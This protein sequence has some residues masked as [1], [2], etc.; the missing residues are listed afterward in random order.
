[1]FGW[2]KRHKILTGL[3]LVPFVLG[4]LNYSGMCI[5]EGR[6]L[7][8]EE[9]IRKVVEALLS[10]ERVPIEIANTGTQYFKQIKYKNVED[11][12]K[13]NPDCCKV[14]PGGP[15]ELPPAS[16]IDRVTGYDTRDPIVS[17]FTVK[18]IDVK[19][20]I[21]SKQVRTTN[22]LMNCGKIKEW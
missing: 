21:Q 9:K 6:W 20:D 14:N 2:M 7:S 8:D 11:F 12:L 17:D 5:P 16:F 13:H 19:G 15:Y 10:Q 1:M 22:V 3:L 4:S 18:Y